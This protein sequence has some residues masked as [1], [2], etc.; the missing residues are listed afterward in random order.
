MS[1]SFKITGSRFRKYFQY[2]N[3]WSAFAINSFSSKCNC[4]SHVQLPERFKHFI[5]AQSI[6]G[7]LQTAISWSFPINPHSLHSWA[8]RESCTSIGCVSLR[9]ALRSM[10][11]WG[12]HVGTSYGLDRMQ[13]LRPNTPAC[14]R[15]RS[16]HTGKI[17]VSSRVI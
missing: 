14:R 9:W 12:I 8:R 1:H 4:M 13:A 2:C 7:T 16:T 11:I 5:F 17:K 6:P 10:R 3:C 15:T